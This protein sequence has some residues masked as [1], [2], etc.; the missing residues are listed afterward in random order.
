MK[1]SK[2]KWYENIKILWSAIGILITALTAF[3]IYN[4]TLVADINSLETDINSLEKDLIKL[5]DTVDRIENSDLRI[6]REWKWELESIL[7]RHG[8]IKY[9]AGIM[10]DTK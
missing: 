9:E 10:K 2:T 7:V 8:I 4:K 1:E 5:N 3:I 6:N